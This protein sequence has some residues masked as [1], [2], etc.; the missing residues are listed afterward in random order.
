M[1]TLSNTLP[2]EA[3]EAIPGV[4]P[5]WLGYD[6]HIHFVVGGDWKS[7]CLITEALSSPAHRSCHA[8]SPHSMRRVGGWQACVGGREKELGCLIQHLSSKP[9][10][11]KEQTL[12]VATSCNKTWKDARSRFPWLGGRD[13][14]EKKKLPFTLLQMEVCNCH[15]HQP[16]A[17]FCGC[18]S[19]SQYHFHI[20]QGVQTPE[21]SSILTTIFTATISK[22]LLSL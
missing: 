5:A 4:L 11:Q 7:L 9:G 15:T 18:V 13:I 14:K 20:I 12:L 16:V 6:P 3:A 19:N 10:L 2:P 22:L 17:Q 1:L 8:D 21:Q